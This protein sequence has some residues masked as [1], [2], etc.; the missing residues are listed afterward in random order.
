MSFWSGRRTPDIDG[1][2]SVLLA[3]IWK[4]LSNASNIMSNAVAKFLNDWR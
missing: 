4:K 1:S 3:S 2:L